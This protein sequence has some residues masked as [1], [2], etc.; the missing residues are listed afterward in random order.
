MEST[1]TS[2][3]IVIVV[4]TFTA[5]GL[6]FILRKNYLRYGIISGLSMVLSMMLCLF[7]YMN[8]FYRFVLPLPIILPTVAVSFTFLTLFS[9]YYK[10][11]YH[12][13]VFYFTIINSVFAIEI[14][15]RHFFHFIVY[16]GPWDTWD[17][18][19]LYWVY[20]RFFAFIGDWI[21]PLKY[22]NP[23]S[24]ESRAYWISFII[25]IIGTIMYMIFIL[26]H[27]HGR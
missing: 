1:L 26:N 16:R 25:V 19:S 6:L 3:L 22:R 10:P 21:V 23:I 4:F 12:S 24:S 2:W 14:L 11:K 15:L 18:Y 9:I 17:S 20:I 7:F 27:W 13:Y 5:G 8:G